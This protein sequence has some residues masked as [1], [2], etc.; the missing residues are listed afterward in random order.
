MEYIF[1]INPAAGKDK[2]A[3]TLVPQIQKI[4]KKHNFSYR[5]H[6]SQGAEEITDYVKSLAITGKEYR[7]Y[8]IGGDGTLNKVINGCANCS[9]V[10]V[11]VIP[12]G[13]GNDFVRNFDVLSKSFFD[14]EAQLLGESQYIDC[15]VQ[16]GE[17]CINRCNIGFDANV[18]VEM[19]KFKKIPMVT[20]H[21]AYNISIFY[22]LIHKLGRPLE[23]YADDELFFKGDVLMCAVANGKACGGGFIVAPKALVND[24]LIDLSVVTPPF[25]RIKLPDF[26][27]NF[28]AGTQ[29]ES[30]SMSKYMNY[31][32]CKKVTLI[33]QK[34][35]SLVN[36][37]EQRDITK[38]EFHIEPN[39]VKFILPAVNN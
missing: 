4:C 16:N 26:L 29:L 31:T 34:V 27:K 33:S 21:M 12:M 32:K 3:L 20:N 8:A 11:G 7:I 30:P 23:I 37:G 28:S 10:E 9:N 1:I 39:A 18:A 6:I 5:V 2:Q 14:I 35:L 38:V 24:G 36:D 17:Y 13:T 19:P 25:S 22:N 15:I